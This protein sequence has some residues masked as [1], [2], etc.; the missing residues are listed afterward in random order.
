M[1]LNLSGGYP[2]SYLKH[3]VIHE[4]GHALGLEHEHQRS[5]FWDVVK[6]FIDMKKMKDDHRFKHMKG[7]KA[8]FGTN[9]LEKKTPTGECIESEYDP[10]SVMHYW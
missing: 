2:E 3:L 6:E 7:E 9:Y 8:G 5:D 10:H 4:F 1:T